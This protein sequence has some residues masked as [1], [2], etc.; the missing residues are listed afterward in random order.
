MG[1]LQTKTNTVPNNERAKAVAENA[2]SIDSPAEPS[3]VVCDVVSDDGFSTG[4]DGDKSSLER[5]SNPRHG[6]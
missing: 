4:F 1:F 6:S 2:I 5:V 3:P